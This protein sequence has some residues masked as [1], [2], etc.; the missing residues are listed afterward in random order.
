MKLVIQNEQLVVYDDVLTAES[1]ATLRCY[2]AN[3]SYTT[4]L[5]SSGWVKSWRPTDGQPFCT[6]LYTTAGEPL[7]NALDLLTG[8]ARETALRHPD[9]IS[10]YTELV[11]RCYLYPRGTRISWHD[12]R[13]AGALTFYV[14]PHWGATWGGELMIADAPPVDKFLQNVSTHQEWLTPEWE[15][16]Y[17]SDKGI[18]L[19]IMPKPNRLVLTAASAFHYV[20]RVDGDAGDQVRAAI[21]GFYRNR[22]L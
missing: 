20:N 22:R 2:V 10:Q 21:V 14:H 7:G 19:W 15:D 1:L 5:I 13:Y 17:L 12:D 11:F 18:G 4:P 9:I 3:E 8:P 6:Q 16:D